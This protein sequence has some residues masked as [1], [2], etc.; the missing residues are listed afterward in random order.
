MSL[1]HTAKWFLLISLASAVLAGCGAIEPPPQ[2]YPH[3]TVS[4]YV[5]VPADTPDDVVVTVVGSA[6]ALGSD[7]A[8]GFRLRRQRE[9]HYTGSL[10][11][12]VGADVSF[13]LWQD[14]VWIPELSAEGSPVP[15]HTFR[16]DGDMTVEATVAR[17]GEPARAPGS[18]KG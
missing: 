1:S 18:N 4:F 2:E 6:A 14:D 16:V 13:D 5:T 17:W 10:R 12:P 15:R 3:A 9:G 7:T 8:P 11:L